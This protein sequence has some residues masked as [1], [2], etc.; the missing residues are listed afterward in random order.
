MQAD[1]FRSA[2]RTR[3]FKPFSLRITGGDEYTIKHPELANITESG[4][5][6]VVLEGEIVITIDTA[7]ISEFAI[8]TGGVGKS[9]G[10][11]KSNG[12]GGA[13]R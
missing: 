1:Q 10:K 3:P 12:A 13:G 7:A 9:K 8:Q 4:R 11:G 6:V 2:L 5:T